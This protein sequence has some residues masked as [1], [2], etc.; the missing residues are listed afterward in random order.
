MII[1]AYTH[2]YNSVQRSILVN[3][4]VSLPMSKDEENPTLQKALW[5]TGAMTTCISTA[6][7]AG[8]GLEP[9]DE[10]SVV[11]ANNEPFKAPVYSVKIKM[12][13]FVIPMHQVIGLPMAGSS[14]SVIIGMDIISLGDLA[15]TN[16]S[17][18]TVITFR[19]P[20]LE[21]INYVD[22]L[23]LQKKCNN[24]HRLNLSSGR[25]DKCACG[26]GKDY[27]NCHGASPYAKY[28]SK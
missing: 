25:P 17:G 23:A 14:H 1:T 21:T 2:P 16:Y 27:K 10:V 3:C 13:S 5:D 7:A 9:T 4:V 24:M 18:R 28:R 12:G 8:L 6:L 20:S 22:E 15:I 26:S 19:T 11:G